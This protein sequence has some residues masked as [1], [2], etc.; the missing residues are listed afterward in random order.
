MNLLAHFI[1]IAHYSHIAGDDGRDACLLGSIDDFLHRWDVVIV[2][3][4][5]DGEIGLDTMLVAGSSNLTQIIDS[6]MVG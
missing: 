5:I 1:A 2:D 4:S 6:K 3:D